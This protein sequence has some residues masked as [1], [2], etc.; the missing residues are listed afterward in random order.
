MRILWPSELEAAHSTV[1]YLV[2]E[3]LPSRSLAT[4]WA[5]SGVG[6]SFLALDLALHVAV[7]RTWHGRQVSAGQ[8]LY[9][10][11]EGFAGMSSRIAAWRAEHSYCETD[12][13]RKI[14]FCTVPFDVSDGALRRAVRDTCCEM[15]LAPK[16]VVF[17]TLSVNAPV[18]FDESKTAHMKLLLDG[19]RALRDEM[20]CAVLFIH[21]TGWDESR[22]RGSSDLRAAMDVSLS[23]ATK[24]GDERELQVVKARDFTPP[25]PIRF[26]LPARHGARVVESLTTSIGS[27]SFSEQA[28]IEQLV[29]RQGIPISVGDWKAACTYSLAHFHR[30]KKQLVERGFVQPASQSRGYVLSDAG[31]ALFALEAST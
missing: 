12:L 16:L 11:G 17:D 3:L 31:Q 1:E 21:H 10:V 7:G 9:V 13:D 28:L 23:L 27:L 20:M 5:P 14:G 24:R 19:A 4:L 6:K 15:A 25:D 22:E 2:A 30:L 8:V 29:A 26:A 18:G